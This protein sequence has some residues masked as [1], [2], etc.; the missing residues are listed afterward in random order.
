MKGNL[1]SVVVNPEHVAAMR[2][3]PADVME[4]FR[5]AGWG[6]Q[7]PHTLRNPRSDAQYTEFII[8]TL[9]DIIAKGKLPAGS[10]DMLTADGQILAT[11]HLFQFAYKATQGLITK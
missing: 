9:D 7:G 2:N 8:R 4:K 6:L 5:A 10:P 11:Q 1:M 3:A